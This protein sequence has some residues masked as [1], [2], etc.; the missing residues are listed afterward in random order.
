MI[1]RATHSSAVMTPDAL[2]ALLP[3]G[4]AGEEDLVLVEA[5]GEDV[6][7]AADVVA[8]AGGEVGGH[9]AGPDVVVVHPQP[10][11]LLEEGQDR[12]PLPEAVDHHRDRAEVH[13]V[14]GQPQHLGRHAVQL[15]HEHAD[16][17][18]PGRDVDLQQLLGGQREHQLV[19]EGRH[20]V[21]AGDVGGPLEVREVL[22]RLLHAGVQVAD[23]RLGPQDRL[24]AELHHHPEHAVGAGVLGP[25]VDDH[26][27][28]VGDDLVDVLGQV[29]DAQDGGLVAQRLDAAGELG[30]LG[31]G[32]GRCRFGRIDHVGHRCV[33]HRGLGAPLNWTG[34]LPMP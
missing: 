34:I 1:P 27:F 12:L 31:G 14:G 32:G 24:A 17:R 18:G 8:P 29:G 4:L 5:L 22:A 21:H 26:G 33:A 2:G 15:A 20:V 16:P 7:D 6:E 13:P 10:G 9:A 19:E 30:R 23:H 25:H 28:V 11:D 3:D